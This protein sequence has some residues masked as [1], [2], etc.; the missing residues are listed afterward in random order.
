[1]TGDVERVNEVV[2]EHGWQYMIRR[3]DVVCEAMNRAKLNWKKSDNISKYDL[4]VCCETN[5]G[6][7]KGR[8]DT[9]I[10]H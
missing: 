2:L 9:Y 3:L 10:G 6:V 7:T 4:Y 8:V 1:M 5:R